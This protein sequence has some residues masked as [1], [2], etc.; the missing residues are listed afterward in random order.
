M[1]NA[2]AENKK[3]KHLLERSSSIHTIEIS[4]MREW[5]LLF[6]PLNRGLI[7]SLTLARLDL[8]ANIFRHYLEK[9]T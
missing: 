2:A 8:Q 1:K 7:D 9:A 3:A 5:L 4:R 6:D